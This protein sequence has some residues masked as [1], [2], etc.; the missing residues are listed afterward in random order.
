[1]AT[2]SKILSSS[3]LFCLSLSDPLEAV[4]KIS[5]NDCAEIKGGKRDL[6]RCEEDRRRGTETVKGQLLQIEE[7]QY[8]VQQFY[9]KEVRLSIDASSQVTGA[10]GLGDSIEANVRIVNNEKLVLFIQQ[11]K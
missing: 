11:L 6:D 1:M 5:P 2:I 7:G 9:G 3:F 4:E 10:L 8:V